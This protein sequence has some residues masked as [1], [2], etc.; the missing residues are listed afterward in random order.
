MV[1]C[2]GFGRILRPNLKQTRLIHVG[3]SCHL[4]LLKF[5][6]GESSRVEKIGLGW[7]EHP[8]LDGRSRD[9]FTGTLRPASLGVHYPL[10]RRTIHLLTSCVNS[11]RSASERPTQARRSASA[12][13]N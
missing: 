9:V 11:R 10:D 1:G 6:L 13:S 4:S 3:L 8:G 7:A 2:V 12:C 5:T